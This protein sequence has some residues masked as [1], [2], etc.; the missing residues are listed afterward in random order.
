MQAHPAL[1]QGRLWC[2]QFK[3]AKHGQHG[4]AFAGC[5]RA[6]KFL[7]FAPGM[8]AAAGLCTT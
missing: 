6:R 4:S 3:V 1:A 7:V 8:K 5:A 2:K